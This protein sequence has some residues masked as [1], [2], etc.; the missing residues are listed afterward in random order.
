M[1]D[2]QIA[3]NLVV[4]AARL[5]LEAMRVTGRVELRLTKR[6]PMGAG[7]GGGS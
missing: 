7:L 2:L 1:D 4:R 3:D 6:I 5:V